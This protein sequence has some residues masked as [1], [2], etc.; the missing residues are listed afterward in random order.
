MTNEEIK[1]EEE[2]QKDNINLVIARID[3]IPSDK[4]ISIGSDG[5]FTKQQLIEEVKNNSEVGRKVIEMQLEY[6]RLL[7]EGIL[8]GQSS[9][10]D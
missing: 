5:E 1:K 8:Y 4:F 7:K 2:K 3:M 6:I 10:S 9:S